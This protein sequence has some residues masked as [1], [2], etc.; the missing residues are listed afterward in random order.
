[1]DNEMKIK[2]FKISKTD[3]LI[4]G[5]VIGIP[6]VIVFFAIMYNVFFNKETGRDYYLS[7]NVGISVHGVVDSIFRQKSN[8]NIL[9]MQISG[10]D[11]F[12]LAPEWAN[13]FLVGDSI[14][15]N[16][17]SLLVEH[18]RADKLLETLDYRQVVKK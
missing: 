8:H 6:V 12:T 7:S 1:M 17:G 5:S 9:T 16:T 14:S 13:K 11:L 2:D 3:N 18:Y 10:G 4:V 15:K